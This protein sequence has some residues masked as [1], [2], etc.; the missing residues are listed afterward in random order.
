[1]TTVRD[2]HER[3][4][5]SVAS[6]RTNRHF[7][8]WENQPLPFKIYTELDAIP[9]PRDLGQ[10]KVPALQAIAAT[11]PFEPR[12]PIP[13]LKELARLLH[14]SA[15]I[16][17]KKE[18]P[19][20]HV[21]YFRAA[22]CTG[23]LYHIDLYVVCGDLPGLPAGVYHF[24]PHD[25]ALRRLRAGDHR[26][27]LVEATAEEPSVVAAPAVIISATTFWRNA[28]KYQARAYR[29]AY[30]DNGTLL[31]NLLAVAAADGVPAKVVVGFVDAPVNTL[32]GL[33]TQ[34]EAA[35]SLV[36]VGDRPDPRPPA[37]PPLAPLKLTTRPLSPSEVDYPLIRE[38][39]AASS[40]SGGAEVRAWREAAVPPRPPASP[41]A[42]ALQPL[43]Q[44]P[45][46]SIEEVIVRRGS[47]RRFSRAPISFAQLS[48]MLHV[49]TRG[50]PSDFLT[51]PAVSL[52]DCYVI[53][54][55][56]DGLAAGSYVFDRARGALELLKQGDFRRQAGHLDLGQELAADA[57]VNF[58]L[59]ADLDRIIA[60][61]G[62]RGYRA[63]QL[64]GAIV[65]GT[66]YLAAY[67]LGLGATGLTFF[68]DDVTEFFSPHAA[69][70]GV[71]FLV[72]AGVP[73][74]QPSR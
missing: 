45:A 62:Q 50:V 7:L 53:V 27:V 55:A 67:A 69:G 60:R 74:R 64:E 15:G 39:H 68:D 58:Y 40:L 71:M 65:G 11:R 3:T 44:P 56:V 5:H 4:K 22:A 43:A 51:E 28:W 35:L 54:S 14:Y 37:A 42:I 33:D 18:Y 52:N 1:M 70:K 16:T 8:D 38:A 61:L 29:H 47:S 20:G 31:A 6:V 63:A 49:A 57:A 17:R 66:L 21:M 48:T 59:M 30:W 10:S 41:A 13:D 26:G 34:R 73:A 19:N 36:P 23:A 46:R 72:A 9:L 24:S 2:Y 25:A 12:R 32:L